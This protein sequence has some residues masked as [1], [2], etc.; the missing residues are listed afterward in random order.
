ML[1]KVLIANRAEIAVRVI[2]ACRALGIASVAVFSDADRLSP[3]VMLA[4]EAY[5]LPGVSPAETYLDIAKIVAIGVAAGCDGVHPGYGFLSE[6]AAFAE[7]CRE[8][9]LTFVGPKPE[10][11][12]AAG[13]KVAARAAA[14]RAGVPVVPGSAEP[15]ASAEEALAFAAEVGYPV[16]L[17]ARS[18]GGGKGIRKVAG[19][20]ELA[21]AFELAANEAR[22]AF[23]DDA[24]YLE[25]LVVD[26][27]HIE[28][29]ILVDR[30]GNGAHFGERECSLQRR[31]QKV[32]EECPSPAVSPEL[33]EDLGQCALRLAAEVGYEGAGTVEF[34]LEDSGAFYFM[35][36]NARL[37]VE[38]PV[39]ELVWGVDL[40]Q[41][42]LRVASGESRPWTRRDAPLGHAVE[43]RVYAEDPGAGF[44][45]S[46]GRIVELWLPGGPGVR[47]DHALRAGM[48]VSLHYDPMLAKLIAGGEDRAEALE[49]ARVALEELWIGGVTDSASFGAALLGR[50]EVRAGDFH[51]GSLET[52]LSDV[53]ASSVRHDPEGAA[54][55][56]ALVRQRKS[57][58]PAE[59]TAAAED[60][61]ISAGRLRGVGR[62]VY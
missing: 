18:G 10:V 11:L 17:K 40:V 19:P 55:A 20:E 3:H 53:A 4:D 24:L 54:L 45:P 7:A 37:Q 43:V 62:V 44:L 33:R 35:E 14:Q 5:P 22:N 46:S 57:P 58:A 9:G 29:Q 13:D 60:R 12:S 26:A 39:T 23:G 59:G 42:Q 1:R 36:V 21:A 32:V 49:R 30:A 47:V 8:A 56:A 16:L 6:N 52:W 50:E 51:T 2:R 34:L 28:V 41:G 15:L 48:E 25:K 27:R 31:H 38:H 61:W